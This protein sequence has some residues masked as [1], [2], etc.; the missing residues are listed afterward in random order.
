MRP[1]RPAA[2]AKPIS[3]RFRVETKKRLAGVARRLRLRP[4][5]IIRRAVEQQL[6]D[7]ERDGR[8]VTAAR[9]EGGR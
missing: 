1:K 5:E 3:C 8:I 7:W 9:A 4:C 2:L 6:P